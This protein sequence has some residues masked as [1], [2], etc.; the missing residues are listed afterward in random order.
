MSY[1]KKIMEPPEI[2]H[3]SVF[4]PDSES[5]PQQNPTTEA[6]CYLSCQHCVCPFKAKLLPKWSQGNIQQPKR[7]PSEV[8]SPFKKKLLLSGPMTASHYRSGPLLRMSSSLQKET[9]A[10]AGPR[11]HPTT[12]AGPLGF[13]DGP[14]QKR[15]CCR[16]GSTASNYRSG[17]VLK[18]SRRTL[19]KRKLTK[20]VLNIYCRCRPVT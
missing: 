6:G 3:F 2:T 10:K 15:N 18:L 17:P 11:Q 7:A 4:V 12:G 5:G 1:E 16:N 20:K 9:A 8:S 14:I 13:Q 19:P